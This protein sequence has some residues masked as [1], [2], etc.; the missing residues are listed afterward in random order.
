MDHLW[1][2]LQC[3][4]LHLWEDL[5]E[6]HLQKADQEEEK[7]KQENLEENLVNAEKPKQHNSGRRAGVHV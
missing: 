4:H 6:D 3:H 7:K 2:D 5:K 1:V